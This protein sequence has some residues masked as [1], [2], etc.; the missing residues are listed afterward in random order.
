MRDFNID[1][2]RRSI[3]ASSKES[4]IYIGCDSRVLRKETM[5]GLALIIHLETSKGGMCFAK[6]VREKRKRRT[7][8][9]LQPQALDHAAFSFS[10]AQIHECWKADLFLFRTY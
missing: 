9:I 8:I 3:V 2:I 7:I 1:E 10:S 6:R 5:F 4:S